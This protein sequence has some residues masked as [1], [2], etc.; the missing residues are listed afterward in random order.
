MTPMSVQRSD[1]D[2]AGRFPAIPAQHPESFEGC[3]C[4]DLGVHI[5]VVQAAALRAAHDA[6]VAE[7]AQLTATIDDLDDALG[8]ALTERDRCHELLDDLAYAVAPV[9]VLGEH[10]SG[11]CP[12]HN[13]LDLLTGGHTH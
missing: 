6:L 4:E 10:S 5:L 8:D 2:R 11:N 7:R 9:E 1:G 12:W 13:A 3:G